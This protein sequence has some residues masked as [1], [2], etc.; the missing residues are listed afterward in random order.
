MYLH[1]PQLRSKNNFSK[2]YDH[3]SSNYENML[4]NEVLLHNPNSVYNSTVVEFQRNVHVPLLVQNAT[5]PASEKKKETN[6]HVAKT[7]ECA[8]PALSPEEGAFLSAKYSESNLNRNVNVSE[9]CCSDK[10]LQGGGA[11]KVY[12]KERINEGTTRM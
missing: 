2:S 1:S 6:K 8:A 4:C 11:G 7:A 5:R 10:L 3:Y 12:D 9:S